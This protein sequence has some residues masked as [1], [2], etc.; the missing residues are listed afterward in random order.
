MLRLLLRVTAEAPV[1]GDSLPTST[2][3]DTHARGGERFA[4]LKGNSWASDQMKALPHLDCS[5][6]ARS[7]S[8]DSR[9]FFLFSSA[10]LKV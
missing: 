9:I 10:S 4:R 8:T 5:H 6:W 7:R 2:D 1:R 3:D